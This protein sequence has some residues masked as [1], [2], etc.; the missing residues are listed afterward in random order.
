MF[1]SS[2]LFKL[3]NLTIDNLRFKSF[4]LIIANNIAIMI[5]QKVKPYQSECK[6][7]GSPA[8]YSY[9]G[10]ISCSACKMFFKRNALSD[11]KLWK[12][13]FVGQC[14]ININNRHVCSSCR[15]SKCFRSG[16]K[17][18]M[19]RTSIRSTPIN[20]NKN[21]NKLSTSLIKLNERKQIPTLNLLEKDISSLNNNQWI[22]L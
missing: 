10:V 1:G 5:K 11:K 6:I 16:M 2:D 15:L 12:C 4:N 7:C 22:L 3:R 14:E 21:K 9:F 13:D 18:E 8:F 19:I 17:A 20:K